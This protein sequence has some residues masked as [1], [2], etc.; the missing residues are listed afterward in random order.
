MFLTIREGIVEVLHELRQHRE[1]TE[2]TECWARSSY[3][4][5]GRA[6]DRK[7]KL[8]RVQGVKSVRNK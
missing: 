8:A 1:D 6:A 2:Y 4:Q 7:V 3:Y 5:L